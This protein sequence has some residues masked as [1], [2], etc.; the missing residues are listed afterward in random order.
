[1]VLDGVVGAAREEARDGGPLVAV[2]GVG[3]EDE[4]VLARREGAVV[5]VGAELVAPAEAAGLAGAA[6]DGGADEAP[7]VG[8]VLLHQAGQQAVLLGAPRPLLHHLHPRRRLM[9]TA[10]S[11][12]FF[13]VPRPPPPLL[14][15]LDL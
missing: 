6:G 4:R 10:I 3:G 14:H 7:A 1:M 12:C 11:R 9:I 2:A 8:A 5:H 13:I 15:S